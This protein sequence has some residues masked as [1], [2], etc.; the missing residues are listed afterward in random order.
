MADGPGGDADWGDF[1]GAGEDFGEFQFVSADTSEVKLVSDVTVHG[2]DL[3]GSA[4][5]APGDGSLSTGTGANNGPATFREAA[6]GL[7][8]EM[9]GSEWGSFGGVT[10]RDLL[11]GGVL[12]V[13]MSVLVCMYADLHL[14][15]SLVV[16]VSLVS[17]LCL[18]RCLCP[19]FLFCLCLRLSAY[20][21]LHFGEGNT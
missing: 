18:L 8:S 14:C 6:G 15:L 11:D 1:G 7:G 17:C 19:G 21:H 13:W 10:A 2:G 9:F 20:E 5:Q 12:C 3:L 4:A 16:P